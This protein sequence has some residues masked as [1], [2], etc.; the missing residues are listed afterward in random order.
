MKHFRLYKEASTI[1]KSSLFDP[2][3]YLHCV[4]V[5]TIFNEDMALERT[6]ARYR[7]VK[8]RPV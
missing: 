5:E 6:W 8:V 7:F 1:H 3:A 2:N 4:H